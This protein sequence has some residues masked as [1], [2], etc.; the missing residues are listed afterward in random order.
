MKIYLAI[1][2]DPSFGEESVLGCYSCY[3]KALFKLRPLI[4]EDGGYAYF[5]DEYE[6]NGKLIQRTDCAI[7]FISKQ[8][9]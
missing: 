4:E 3:D 9:G 7:K 5:I 6:L 8:S 2:L 1:S